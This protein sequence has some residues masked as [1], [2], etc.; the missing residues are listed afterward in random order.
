MNSTAVRYGFSVYNAQDVTFENLSV[1]DVYWTGT[2]LQ[3]DATETL[4]F[5]HGSAVPLH[6]SDGPG[7]HAV[8]N[9]GAL[10]GIG[11]VEGDLL[12]PETVIGDE[13]G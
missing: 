7:R 4:R 11:R 3:L 12:R 1:G 2:D 13:P 10:L 5:R 6:G 9:D 8:F